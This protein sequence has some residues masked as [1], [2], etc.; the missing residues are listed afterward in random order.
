[1]NPPS[2]RIGDILEGL[3]LDYNLPDHLA[4]VDWFRYP[5]KTQPNWRV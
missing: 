2:A 4:C 1:M 3:K 5:S